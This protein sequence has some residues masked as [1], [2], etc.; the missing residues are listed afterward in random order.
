MSCDGV[1]SPLRAAALGRTWDCGS[2]FFLFNMVLVYSLRRSL[3]TLPLQT[4]V[5]IFTSDC[6]AS[7]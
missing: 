6:S 4:R 2:L 5:N 7:I 1:S 3:E